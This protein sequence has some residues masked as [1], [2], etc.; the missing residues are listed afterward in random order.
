MKLRAIGFASLSIFLA[1][2]K[3]SA[4]EYQWGL[5]LGTM[6]QSQGYKEADNKTNITPIISYE[7]ENLRIN[8]P[9][10]EYTLLKRKVPNVGGFKLSLI[11]QYRFEGYDSDDSDVLEGMDERSGAFEAGISLGYKNKKSILV[12]EYLQD[13]SNSHEGNEVS[14]TY[15]RPYSFKSLTLS[16][17]ARVSHFSDDFVNYYYGVES[18]EAMAFRPTYIGSATTSLETGIKG[19]WE[20]GKRH[21]F[22]T[23]ISYER[24]GKEVEDSPLIEES[25]SAK[26][27]LGY[28]YAF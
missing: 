16:P 17:Y 6:F 23:N 1:S 7:S 18:N 10:A 24:F 25:G 28:V 15:L 2:S 3:L 5:G 26:L 11:G 4:E 8:G 20:L 19:V 14:L 27:A 13:I 22:I 21:R 12:L 9:K